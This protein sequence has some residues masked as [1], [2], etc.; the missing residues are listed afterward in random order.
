MKDSGKLVT[1]WV[2]TSSSLSLSSSSSSFRA[3]S[4]WHFSFSFAEFKLDRWM[5]FFIEPAMSRLDCLPRPFISLLFDSS[6]CLIKWDNRR[7]VNSEHFFPLSS[8]SRLLLHRKISKLIRAVF[9]YIISSWCL[10]F[11]SLPLFH[12]AIYFFTSASSL[13]LLFLPSAIEISCH[14]L[15]YFFKDDNFLWQAKDVVKKNRTYGE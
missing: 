6:L 7:A 9:N 14:L 4:V 8:S 12:S 5:E 1:F 11:F 10:R 3:R 15:W 2:S 13:P